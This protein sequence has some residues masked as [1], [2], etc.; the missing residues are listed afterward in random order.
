MGPRSSFRAV[1]VASLLLSGCDQLLPSRTFE[2]TFSTPADGDITF[3]ATKVRIGFSQEIDREK[4][5]N[6]LSL[7]AIGD[8]PRVAWTIPFTLQAWPDKANGWELVHDDDLVVGFDHVLTIETGDSG[9][10]SAHGDPI[11]PFAA[12]FSVEQQAGVDG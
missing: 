1:A 3:P 2:V 7:V 6:A 9:C 5:A 8:D 10:V 12:Q 4:C 11:T